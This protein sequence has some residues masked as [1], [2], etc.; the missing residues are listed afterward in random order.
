MRSENDIINSEN[1]SVNK[2]N[3]KE[4]INKI[5]LVTSFK[6]DL[7]KLIYFQ[8]C[9]QTAGAFAVVSYA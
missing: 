5:Q 8:N 9:R 6:P 7:L 1:Y 3:Y 4:N 2:S